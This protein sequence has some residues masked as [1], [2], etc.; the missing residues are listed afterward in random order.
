MTHTSFQSQTFLMTSKIEWKYSKQKKIMKIPIQRANLNFYATFD[1]ANSFNKVHKHHH[2]SYFT[3]VEL[4]IVHNVDSIYLHIWKCSKDF[5]VLALFENQHTN[6]ILRTFCLC[7]NIFD[8]DV[9]IGFCL[10][11]DTYK[12]HYDSVIIQHLLTYSIRAQTHTQHIQMTIMF[13]V[14]IT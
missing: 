5:I 6:G 13:L 3:K 2:S 11:F 4:H 8:F 10:I 1:V 7:D 14:Q 12:T 9:K